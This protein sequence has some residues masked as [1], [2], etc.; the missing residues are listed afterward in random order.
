MFPFLN[1]SAVGA[2]RTGLS[3]WQATAD[4]AAF[5]V[6]PRLGLARYCVLFLA[7]PDSPLNSCLE[8]DYGPDRAPDV[9]KLNHADLGIYTIS[10]SSIRHVRLVLSGRP[11]RF[12]FW[13]RVARSRHAVQQM[14]ASS[15]EEMM[16]GKGPAPVCEIFSGVEDRHDFAAPAKRRFKGN[17]QHYVKLLTM[18]ALTPIKA[19][20]NAS[21][22]P[23]LSF[24]VPV[25][26]TSARHLDDLHASFRAQP[27]GTAEL[28]MSD[29][30]STS[31]ET[32]MWL[33]AHATA[34]FVK[35]VVSHENRGIAAATNAGIAAAHGVWIGLVDHDD[36]LSPFAVVRILDALHKH[37]EAAF[38]YTDEV[39]TDGTLKPVGYHMKPAY[40][41][42]LLSGVNYINHLSL[43]RRDRL[44]KIGGLRPGYEGSQ[45]YD[46]LL[47]Y[48]AGLQ[49]HE[50]LHLPFPAYLWRRHEQSF[51]ATSLDRAL[52]SARCALGEQY[53]SA[54]TPLPVEGAIGPTL[55]RVR[56][57]KV[58][59]T[60]P[61]VSIVIPSRDSY[62]LIS[63]LFEGLTSRTDYPELEIIVVD[64]GTTDARV[65]KLYEQARTR[66][67]G[68]RVE[69]KPEA[70]NFSRQVN[71]G[72]GLATGEHVLLLN[73]DIE[74]TDPQW[75]REMV[76]CLAYPRTGI[77]GARLL[78]PDRSLQHAGVIVGLSGLA[79]HW[80]HAKPQDFP[81]MMGRLN[82]RQSLSAVTAACMLISRACL[83]EVGLFDEEAFAVAY[84]DVDY[85]LRA[86]K[87]GYRIVWTPFATLVHHESASRGSDELPANTARF[88]REKAA[89]R[90]RHAT[91]TFEDPAFSPW[92]HR[93]HSD[94]RLIL[95]DRLPEPR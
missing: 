16:A 24:V 91:D 30:G 2:K 7:T 51:S 80:Y 62:E 68:F 89:L 75:L 4:K 94:G 56:L 70:F 31:D 65:L 67:P 43:Y 69:I 64:N 6:R 25:Y 11:A 46:L 13:A 79:G 53:G 39:I 19:Q 48:L 22:E 20:V 88:A 28:I 77:V 66:I 60:W 40:D 59:K 14:V 58:V 27:E 21:S 86:G 72:I 36:A 93:G 15:I 90:E 18:A 34:P 17:A 42:V 37:P 47:R 26:N 57:D 23:Q 73:N 5:T 83:D 95:L 71:R 38:L 54:E 87:S 63:R 41:P 12:R 76:S 82:V 55:H 52:K 35:V 61:K 1:L 9:R 8:V 49:R 44:L 33:S 10:G 78:Y 85:C 81:G 92:F 32:R 50:I 3:T 29:D 45:D 84:N 74:V